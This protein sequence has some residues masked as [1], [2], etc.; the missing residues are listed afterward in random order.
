M[1]QV[2]I[3]HNQVCFYC[4]SDTSAKIQKNITILLFFSFIKIQFFTRNSR[5]RLTSFICTYFLQEMSYLTSDVLCYVTHKHRILLPQVNYERNC[6]NIANTKTFNLRNKYVG[7]FGDKN[8]ETNTKN[9]EQKSKFLGG[10]VIQI[11]IAFI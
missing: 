5:I 10:Q 6:F 2:P 3:D 9:I 8:S 7:Q 1:S 11:N 4:V